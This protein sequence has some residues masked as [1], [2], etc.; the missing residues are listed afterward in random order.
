MPR[1]M[2]PANREVQELK[3]IQGTRGREH[4]KLRA[5]CHVRAQQSVLSLLSPPSTLLS[6][7]SSKKERKLFITEIFP[8][9]ELFYITVLN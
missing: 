2:L 6:I 4:Q 9:R 7:R 3:M 1:S 5:A 8:A